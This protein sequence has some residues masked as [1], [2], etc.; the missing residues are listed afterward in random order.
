[1][2]LREGSFPR[3]RTTARGS[4]APVRK[5]LVGGSRRRFGELSASHVDAPFF[6]KVVCE[7]I[8][9]S[10]QETSPKFFLGQLSHKFFFP[11]AS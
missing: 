8:C 4:S 5:L 10:A 3:P 6:E 2:L 9:P 1:M 7:G 11:V